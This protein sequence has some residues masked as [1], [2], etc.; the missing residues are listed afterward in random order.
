MKRRATSLLLVMLLV[1]AILPISAAADDSYL[2]KGVVENIVVSDPVYK[3]NTL[4]GITASFKWISDHVNKAYLI[5]SSKKLDGG[6][7]GKEWGVFSSEGTIAKGQYAQGLFKTLDEA[8]AHNDSHG[9]LYGFI[10]D[11][12]IGS[13]NTGTVKNNLVFDFQST[14]ISLNKNAIYYCYLWIEVAGE[15][16]PDC[17]I[18]VVQ[19]QDGVLKFAP[20]TKPTAADFEQNPNLHQ[21]AQWKTNIYR[22]YY[23]PIHFEAVKNDSKNPN[24]TNPTQH[25]CDYTPWAFDATNH[26]RFC[27]AANHPTNLTRNLAMVDKGTHVYTDAHDPDCNSCGYKRVIADNGPATGDITNIPLWAS[28]FLAGVALMYVQ[29]TQR[30]REQF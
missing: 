6:D 9:N 30:K 15:C 3:D 12:S 26:W 19:V 2:T 27:K 25:V 5:L 29:L 7:D 23:N 20:A 21:N 11:M 28:L 8:K 10:K 17:L 13:L 1:I 16:Y 24:P 4:T 18:F 22:N 14:P